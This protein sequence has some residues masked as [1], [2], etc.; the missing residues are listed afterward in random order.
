[1]TYRRRAGPTSV[2]DPGSTG[3]WTGVVDSI[4]PKVYA[5]RR[6][7]GMTSQ[8]L[9]HVADGSTAAVHKVERGDMVPT[10]T[11]LLA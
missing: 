6:E 3:A 11:T 9:A 2:P 5:L 10:I 8:Q 4:G 1:M 7:R